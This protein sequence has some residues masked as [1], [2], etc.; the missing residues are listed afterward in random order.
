MSFSMSAIVGGVLFS[1]IGVFLLRRGKAEA[2]VW[3]LITGVGLLLFPY[4]VGDGL[5]LWGIGVGLIALAW[6]KR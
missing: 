5:E 6:I 4:F 3:S 1:A 2:N